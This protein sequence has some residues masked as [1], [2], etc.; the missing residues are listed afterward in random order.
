MNKVMFEGNA[1]FY[2]KPCNLNSLRTVQTK[3]DTSRLFR[4][5]KVVLLMPCVLDAMCTVHAKTWIANCLQSI[6][7]ILLL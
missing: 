2:S 6:A 4:T 7:A 3:Q 5:L 1:I